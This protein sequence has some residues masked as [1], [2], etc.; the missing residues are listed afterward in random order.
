MV[1]FQI[2]RLPFSQ[3]LKNLPN[4]KNINYPYKL[5]IKTK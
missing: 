2:S 3:L 5:Y 4:F 1:Q